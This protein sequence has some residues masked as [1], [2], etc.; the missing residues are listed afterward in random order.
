M[1]AVLDNQSQEYW[2]Y[3]LFLVRDNQLLNECYIGQTKNINRRLRE[4]YRNSRKGKSSFYLQDFAQKNKALIRV[5]ILENLNCTRD[6]I[7]EREAVWIK[8]VLDEGFILPG[9]NNW[10]KYND[11]LEN[12][13]T[14]VIINKNKLLNQSALLTQVI[15][16]NTS[17]L[18]SGHLLD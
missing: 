16:N 9:L 6:T 13:N 7:D 18:P 14:R 10:I 8:S 11:K 17:I 15:E 3:G 1:T 4:H 5:I 12:V 2:I